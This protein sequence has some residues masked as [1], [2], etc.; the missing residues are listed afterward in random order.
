[1]M[2]MWMIKSRLQNIKRN[3]FRPECIALECQS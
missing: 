3:T 2:Y 1:M